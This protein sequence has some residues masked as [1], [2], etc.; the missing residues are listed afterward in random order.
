MDN[1]QK[2]RLKVNILKFCI[3]LTIGIFLVLVIPN[4]TIDPWDLISPRFLILVVL[5][6]MGL[7]FASYILLE[8]RKKE[9]LLIMGALIGIVNSNIINGAMASITKQDPRISDHAASAIVCGNLAMLARNIILVSVLCTSASKF[10]IPPVLSML[11]TGIIVIFYRIKRINKEIK[12]IDVNIKNPFAIKTTLVFTGV[13][14]IITIAG[15]IIH[16]FFGD[17]G[18]YVT[19][20]ISVYAAGGPIIISSIML[21]EA[22]HISYMTGATVII[23]ASISSCSNDAIIQFLCGANSLAIS[24]LKI[25]IPMLAAGF[26]ALGIEWLIFNVT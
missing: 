1:E 19:A 8:L 23:I 26:L 12:H 21:A 11:I 9:G 15:F 7:Q 4:K 10:V 24:F 14:T 18:L 6:V 13:I 3:F 16:K 17:M 2:N 25:T 20:F 22:G 5:M